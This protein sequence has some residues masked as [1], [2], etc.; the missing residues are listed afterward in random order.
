[1]NDARGRDRRSRHATSV[2]RHRKS[3]QRPRLILPNHLQ[4][5]FKVSTK[6]PLSTMASKCKHTSPCDTTN[7][8]QR[9]TALKTLAI[10]RANA[11]VT[12]AIAPKPDV[13]RAELARKSAMRPSLNATTVSAAGGTAAAMELS[14]STT[15]DQTPAVALASHCNPKCKI[16]LSRLRCLTDWTVLD[17]IIGGKFYQ[18]QQRKILNTDSPRRAPMKTDV[19]TAATSSL[20]HHGNIESLM[21]RFL[22]TYRLRLI[23]TKGSLQL[24]FQTT[25][26]SLTLP[27]TAQQ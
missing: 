18:H 3:G 5:T 12:S 17:M 8:P 9:P 7:H 27:C 15:K 26:T 23:T 16:S 22:P 2:R 10:H 19:P 1:M 20:L 6:I 11:S 14:L 21:G 4:H 24:Q 13:T 25:D